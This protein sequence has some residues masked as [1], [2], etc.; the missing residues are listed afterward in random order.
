MIQVE[1]LLELKLNGSEGSMRIEV[2]YTRFLYNDIVWPDPNTGAILVATQM[3]DHF[4]KTAGA[5][6]LRPLTISLTN[7]FGQM[8]E[9][10]QLVSELDQESILAWE[11]YCKMV[12]ERPETIAIIQ[13]SEG[14]YRCFDIKTG[15]AEV[16]RRQALI[17]QISTSTMN[18]VRIQPFSWQVDDVPLMT[19]DLQ[20][21]DDAK[22]LK[23]IL[24]S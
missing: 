7:D 12:A 15:Q 13:V 16:E 11:S 6:R 19:G 3:I 5:V 17:C 24:D 14:N 8:I 21:I 1:N 10:H 20:V 9:Y 18:Q 22:I 23:S 2:D 4:F